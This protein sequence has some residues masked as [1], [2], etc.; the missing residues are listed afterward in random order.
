VLEEF[1][2][3]PCGRLPK[4]N[5]ILSPFF[6]GQKIQLKDKKI[7]FQDKLQKPISGLSI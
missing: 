2:K 6:Y 4:G 5:E 1:Q 3:K 7:W